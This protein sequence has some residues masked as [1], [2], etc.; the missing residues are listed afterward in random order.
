MRHTP[1]VEA[2][3]RAAPPAIRRAEREIAQHVVT[4]RKLRGLTQ[5][6]LAERAGV[7]RDTVRR[8]ESA[9]NGVTVQS[10]L[11]VLRSLGVLENVERALDPLSSEIGRLRAEER[12][13][14]RVRPKRLGSVSDA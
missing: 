4:W 7:S 14:Q 11:R 8:V 5:S 10:L 6:Q 2:T 1:G 12:L 3:T 9:E 13:P